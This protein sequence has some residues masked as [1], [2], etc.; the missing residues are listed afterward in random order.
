MSSCYQYYEVLL[1]KFCVP[2]NSEIVRKEKCNSLGVLRGRGLR[3]HHGV[4]AM[5][6]GHMLSKVQVQYVMPLSNHAYGRV[7]ISW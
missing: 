1:T 2:K 4:V 5:Y 7:T 6:V 3:R